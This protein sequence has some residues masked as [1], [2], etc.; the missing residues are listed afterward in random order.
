M[1]IKSYKENIETN[2]ENTD[3]LMDSILIE[4]NP[5]YGFWDPTNPGY[6]AKI[7]EEKGLPLD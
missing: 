7:A 6:L 3:I 2:K 5:Y 4:G 1:K